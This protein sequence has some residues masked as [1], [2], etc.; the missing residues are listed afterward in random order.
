M[1]TLW[2]PLSTVQH[3]E[4]SHCLEQASSLV[5]MKAIYLTIVSA[6]PSHHIPT[7]Q[8]HPQ[9]VTTSERLKHYSSV[10]FIT[11][12]LLLLGVSETYF[13]LNWVISF[14]PQ[15][16]I[17]GS[18]HSEASVGKQGFRILCSLS[19]SNTPETVDCFNLDQAQLNK[20][21]IGPK[22]T[23]FKIREDKAGSE[24]RF[25]QVPFPQKAFCLVLK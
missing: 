9:R 16:D 20:I 2:S 18:L 4:P 3:P 23:M 21:L 22:R 14:A 19:S 7:S 15:T 17:V 25:S 6:T 1:I 10:P 11:S 12:C 5:S 24:I 8:A 13:C